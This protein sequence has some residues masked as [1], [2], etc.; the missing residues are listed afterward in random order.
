MVGG[1]FQKPLH[2]LAA[3]GYCAFEDDVRIDP[4]DVTDGRPTDAIITFSELFV[5][6]CVDRPEVTNEGPD[7]AVAPSFGV[8]CWVYVCPCAG[9]F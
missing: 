3:Y 9:V 1:D 4:S 7:H 5:G 6:R 8:L 2:L